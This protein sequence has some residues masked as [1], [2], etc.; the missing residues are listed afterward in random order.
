MQIQR[1]SLKILRILLDLG[2]L[3]ISF[4]TA[5]ICAIEIHFTNNQLADYGIIITFAIGVVWFIS[6]KS[7]GLYDEFRSRNFSFELIAI[8]KNL[9]ATTISL[10]IIVFII[11]ESVF[12]RLFILYFSVTALILLTTERYILRLI[13]N[14]MRKMGRNIRSLLIVGAGEVG[15]DFYDIIY[16]NPHFGYKIIGFLD[17]KVKTFLN[18]QYLG[19]IGELDN[20]LATKQIDDVI[21]ALPNY[22]TERL[23][24]VRSL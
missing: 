8:T 24:W 1:R 6:S 2:S 3:I 12:S 10:I 19:T 14:F 5:S 20:V 21:I 7:N 11:K 16:D 23:E 18:G 17:D 4:I 15:K 9:F 22:A 13:L